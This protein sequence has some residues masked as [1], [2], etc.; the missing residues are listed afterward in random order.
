MAAIKGY[1]LW[2][3]DGYCDCHHKQYIMSTIP[4][5]QVVEV[6]IHVSFSG[7]RGKSEQPEKVRDQ[8]N[9]MGGCDSRTSIAR[10]ERSGWPLLSQVMTRQRRA[11]YVQLGRLTGTKR[12]SKRTR[13]LTDR[14]LEEIN[15]LYVSVTPRR[16]RGFGTTRISVRT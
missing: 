14:D 16:I 8:G 2:F 9:A 12:V 5:R 15:S 3:S 1:H 6:A 7:T 13:F 10:P 4:S 11:K